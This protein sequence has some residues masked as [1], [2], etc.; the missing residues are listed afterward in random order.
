MRLVI[1]GYGYTARA[2]HGALA[3]HLDA[4]TVTTRTADKAE[5]LRADG[6]D[7]AV[8]DGS[9]PSP[10]LTAALAT[11]THLIQT[12]APG[13]AGDPL[14]AVYGADAM[15]NLIWAGYL[16]TTGVYGGHDGDWVNEETPT[17]PQSLRSQW[18]VDAENDWLA[19]GRSSGCAVGL[20]R[21]A[22]IYGPGRSPLDRIRAGDARR[23]VKPGQVFNRIHVA[24]IARILAAAAQE[25]RGGVFNVSDDEPAPAQDV[26]VHAATLLG[27]EPPQEVAFEDADLSPMGRS[28][29]EENKR[30]ANDRI[31]QAF[32]PLTY[33]TYR[34]GLAALAD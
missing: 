20:F 28:F 29:Y 16:S 12:A 26:T 22:G 24:D 15:P 1:V 31:K 18:R 8:F 19:F 3:D 9:S 32:G 14:L 33:P 7:V 10:D 13:E 30:V 6:L 25:G 4:L 23:I 5:A 21:L 17:T 27:V 34:E 11:A 2:I